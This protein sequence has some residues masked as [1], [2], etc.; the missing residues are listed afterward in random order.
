MQKKLTEKNEQ[1]LLT[2]L[3]RTKE[4][5]YTEIGQNVSLLERAENLRDDV[6]GD[7]DEECYFYSTR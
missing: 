3:K 4:G 2:F 6:Y 7:I 1:A 5:E